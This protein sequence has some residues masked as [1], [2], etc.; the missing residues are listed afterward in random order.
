MGYANNRPPMTVRVKKS[1]PTANTI[2]AYKQPGV[3]FGDRYYTHKDGPFEVPA[4]RADAMLKAGLV[5]AVARMAVTEAE[6]RAG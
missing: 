2:E 6:R 4:E 3:F 5:D 1:F